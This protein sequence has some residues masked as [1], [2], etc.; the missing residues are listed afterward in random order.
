MV[1]VPAITPVTTPDKLSTEAMAVAEEAQRPPETVLVSV[2]VD[3]GQTVAVPLIIPAEGNALTVTTDVAVAT[4]QLL[5]TVYDITVV[6]EIRAVTKPV[7]ESIEATDVLLEN[8]KP[9]VVS[10]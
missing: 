1:V 4:P 8:Q 5:V 9:P 10:E 7:T 3:A 2:V 6:P